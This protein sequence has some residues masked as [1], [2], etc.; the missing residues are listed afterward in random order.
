[1]PLATL[2]RTLLRI[3]IP[4]LQQPPPTQKRRPLAAV[5]WEGSKNFPHEREDSVGFGLLVFREDEFW[6]LRAIVG[7][8]PICVGSS[9]LGGGRSGTKFN[10]RSFVGRERFGKSKEKKPK[11][12]YKAAKNKI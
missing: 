12:I 8:V 6:M 3:R 4:H 7:C 9:S 2:T 10:V 11:P 5:L 1:M